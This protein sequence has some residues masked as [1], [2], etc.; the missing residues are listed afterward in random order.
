MASF[1]SP[2]TPIPRPQDK[3]TGSGVVPTMS[4]TVG[5]TTKGKSNPEPCF[6]VSLLCSC[7]SALQS[8]ALVMYWSENY[9]LVVGFSM[10]GSINTYSLNGVHALDWELWVCIG[11]S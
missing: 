5:Q 7:L 1:S 9:I 6:W 3:S 11:D 2:F 10:I 8:I 4:S